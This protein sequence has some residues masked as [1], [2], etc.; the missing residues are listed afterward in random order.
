M[1][2][3]AFAEDD[4]SDNEGAGEDAVQQSDASDSGDYE[5]TPPP[6]AFK[7]RNLARSKR[8]VESDAGDSDEQT[9]RSKKSDKKKPRPTAW[10]MT[11]FKFV[12]DRPA[13]KALEFDKVDMYSVLQQPEFHG[14][15]SVNLAYWK[16]RRLTSPGAPL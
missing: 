9:K 2:D 15:R 10:R 1:A 11:R 4:G 16:A 7:P 8:A 5:A 3:A 13:H 14:I 6:K 12:T